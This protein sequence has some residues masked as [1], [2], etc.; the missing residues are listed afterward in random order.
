MSN[1]ETLRQAADSA[2]RAYNAASEEASAA[3]K[4]HLASPDRFDRATFTEYTAAC[5]KRNEVFEVFRAASKA[6]AE[7]EKASR[8][9][10]KFV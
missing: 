1:L 4:R 6:W 5:D 10:F 8:P 7:A 3:W 2:Y 9:A